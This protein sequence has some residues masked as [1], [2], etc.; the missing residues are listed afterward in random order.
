MISHVY[1]VVFLTL[2]LVFITLGVIGI[3]LPLLPTT[4]FLILAAYCFSKSSEKLHQWL[5][6]HKYLGRML[7]DWEKYGVIRLR[8][9]WIAT[10]SMLLLISYPMIFIIQH[11]ILKVIITITMILVLLFIW[12]RPSS[13]KL[14]SNSPAG[15]P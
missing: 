15:E 1:R 3:F 6:H 10:L 13:P 14:A 11:S 5:L 2:G 4:P 8:I 9:K 12:T 7:S